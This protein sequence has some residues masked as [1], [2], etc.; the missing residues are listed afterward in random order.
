MCS[1]Q[2]PDTLALVE[3]GLLKSS[4]RFL[5][6]LVKAACCGPRP[7]EPEPSWALAAVVMGGEIGGER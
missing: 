1:H 3:L 2:G 4:S 7:Q 5:I 6:S